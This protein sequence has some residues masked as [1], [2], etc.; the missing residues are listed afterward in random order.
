MTKS[1]EK[2]YSQKAAVYYS[3]LKANPTVSANAIGKRYGGTPLSMRKQDRNDL[4]KSLKDGI[5]FDAR[6]KNSDA[7]DATRARLKGV[8]YQKAKRQTRY[9]QNKRP[10][11]VGEKRRTI[12]EVI[13]DTFTFGSKPTDETEFYGP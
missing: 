2:S 1:K 4:V 7:L 6:L 11:P 9:S 10:D 3:V 13:N 8:M 5:E 12:R